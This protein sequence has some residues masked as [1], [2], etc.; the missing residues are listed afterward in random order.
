MTRE[1]LQTARK[2]HIVINKEALIRLTAENSAENL[3][4]R[5]EWYDIFEVLKEIKCHSRTLFSAKLFYINKEKESFQHNR[6]LRNFITTDL[7]LKQMLKGILNL[8]EKGVHLPMG[9]QMKT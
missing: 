3:R 7:V 2:N 5:R 6:I 4:A 9:K 8:Q 1:I